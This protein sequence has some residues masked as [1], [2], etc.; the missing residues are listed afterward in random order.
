MKCVPPHTVANY[1]IACKILSLEQMHDLEVGVRRNERNCLTSSHATTG[2]L[3]EVIDDLS[4]LL[5]IL[6][7]SLV[8]DKNHPIPML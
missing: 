8:V 5:A 3:Q 4:S 6:G 1:W 7:K 2:V